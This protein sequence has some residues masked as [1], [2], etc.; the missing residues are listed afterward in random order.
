MEA[1]GDEGIDRLALDDI[2]PNANEGYPP[3]AGSRIRGLEGAAKAL[4]AFLH[5]PG[6]IYPKALGATTPRQ[7]MK[8]DGSGRRD[9]VAKLIT[10]MGGTLESFY[11]AFGDADLPRSLRVVVLRDLTAAG[12]V[13]SSKLVS[14]E[15]WSEQREES[16]G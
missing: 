12:P 15:A 16:C 4:L 10:N 6:K 3:P 14:L 9:A 13:L 1:P 11:F 7:V 5:V 8:N 2:E